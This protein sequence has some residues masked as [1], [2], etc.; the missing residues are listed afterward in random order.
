MTDGYDQRDGLNDGFGGCRFCQ[1]GGKTRF[2]A[3]SKVIVHSIA[4][5]DILLDQGQISLDK[6]GCTRMVPCEMDCDYENFPNESVVRCL[7][8]GLASAFRSRPIGRFG[9]G[10]GN[11]P[12][13]SCHWIGDVG[14]G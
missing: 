6:V 11:W 9:S 7:F 13:G 1:M 12:Q 3:S 10:G 5:L 2:M 4:Q 8:G 14:F